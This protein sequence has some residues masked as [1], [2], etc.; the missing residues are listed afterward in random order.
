VGPLVGPATVGPLPVVA[1]L[2]EGPLEDDP[3]LPEEVSPLAQSHVLGHTTQHTHAHTHTQHTH[4]HTHWNSTSTS[5]AM[6]AGVGW[7][8]LSS[9]MCFCDQSGVVK[10]SVPSS[11]V[12]G[13]TL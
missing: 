10:G 4:T 5:A 2:P 13:S 11:I 7:I 6:G 12:L 1:T 3:P 8:G 9:R